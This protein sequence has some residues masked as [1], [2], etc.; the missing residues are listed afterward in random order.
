MRIEI[1]DISRPDVIALLEF[2][3][4]NM[5]KH[6]PENTSY[7]LDIGALKTPDMTVYTIWDG[8]KLTGC[9]ALREMDDSYAEIKS[10]RAAQGFEGRG[11]GQ[12]LLGHLIEEARQRGYSRLSLETGTTPLFHTAI[13]LYARSGF[14]LGEPFSDYVPSRYNIFMHMDLRDDTRATSCFPA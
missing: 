8:D 10:M 12:K 4:L 7:A 1:D 9:A 5:A 3:T 11:V 6:S 14:V 13:A 2:H